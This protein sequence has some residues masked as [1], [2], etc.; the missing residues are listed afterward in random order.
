MYI[1]T[2]IVEAGFKPFLLSKIKIFFE[3][4]DDNKTEGWWIE[5]EWII[6]WSIL[7]DRKV[8]NKRTNKIY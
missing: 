7:G 4:V 3:I 2:S 1:F 8:L 6:D 5:G